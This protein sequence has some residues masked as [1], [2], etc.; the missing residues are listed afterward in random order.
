M[1]YV[2]DEPALLEI[3]TLYLQKSADFAVNTAVSAHEALRKLGK[4]HCDV[5]VSDYE[6]PGM[7]GID[8]LKD[9]RGT[10]GDIPFILFTGRGREEV[11]IQ[12]INF[13]ADFYLQKGGDPKAQFAELAH[14]IRQAFSRKQ[15]EIALYESEKRLTD[16]INFLPDAT[17]AIDE[18]SR[19]IAWNRAIEEMTG[20]PA[21]NMLGKGDYAYAIPLY[22]SRRPIL[23]DLVF[24]RGDE[25]RSHYK[26]VV[27]E[28]DVL[29]AESTLPALQGRRAVILGTAS[30][31]YNRQGKIV[32]A[33]ESIRDITDVKR[34]EE[35]LRAANEQL[36]GAAEE[37]EGQ[38]REL[39]QSE[40]LIRESEEK[41]RFV[42]ENSH[43]A[44]YI[45]RD[46]EFLFINKKASDMT[47]YTVDQL[48]R[49]DVWDIV[50]PDDRIRLQ[51]SMKR[52][53]AGED[54]SANF[55]ARIR[56]KNGETRYGDFFVDRVIYQGRPAILGIVK[57][58]TEQKKSDS[59]LLQSESRYAALFEHMQEGVAY[60]RMLY[61]QDGRP[62]DWIYLSV[63]PAFETLTGLKNSTGK[64][65]T[66]AIPGIM[67]MD[68]DLIGIYDRVVRTGRPESFERY[69]KPLDMWLNLS[70]FKPEP[71]HFVAIFNDITERKRT[72]EAL[73]ESEQY[74]SHLFE[75]ASDGIVIV[76][77]GIIK[78]MNNRF[79]AFLDYAPDNL[80]DMPIRTVLHPDEQD[81]VLDN[82]VRRISGDLGTV[83]IYPIRLMTK[84]GVPV[85][86][87]LNT[88]LIN[89]NGAPATLNIARDIHQRKQAEDMIR[90]ANKKLSLLSNITRHDVLNKLTTLH[91][92]IELSGECYQADQKFRS[93]VEKE[94]DNISQIHRIISFTKDYEEIGLHSPK[95]KKLDNVI[96][97]AGAGLDLSAVTMTIRAGD[98]EI[99]ADPLLENVFRNLIDNSLHYGGPSLSE[100]SISTTRIK[101]DLVITVEDNGAG[102][103]RETKE[104][105]FSRG[106][107]RNTGLGLFLSKEILSIT[108]ITI[109]ETGEPG[110]GARF[111]ITVPKEA[112]RIKSP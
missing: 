85:W 53:M 49:T 3:T 47:G 8:F 24:S 65:V 74:Y 17:F 78:K 110:T 56:T 84:N 100:I 22:G 28:K 99:Y 91:G 97:K 79:A 95:W 13:G 108:E 106:Y 83:G 93:I 23:I 10:Y 111:E 19:V 45:Y 16:I 81:K 64:K 36:A 7:D 52:R 43:D 61:D 20:I 87:E 11:V 31:L 76:Q 63:N 35:E 75:L 40:R 60:C 72:E 94:R 1:L 109:T 38:Y 96:R 55:T 105:L 89:W 102:I 26:N 103:D 98:Y 29:I 48:M 71:D 107:G 86:V 70:V 82:H 101:G 77:E 14:K 44:I 6:M 33:I 51:A 50:D 32:G 67:E 66:D 37:L 34:S 5:I 41:Y 80:V 25:I 104:H 68:P 69:F 57:D 42:V 59:A 30:P 9:V 12:A 39:L 21:A 62:S 54:I 4:E 15:A 73:K 18:E 46:N 58:T 27:Q 2:D 92:L 90:E 112:W 88:T